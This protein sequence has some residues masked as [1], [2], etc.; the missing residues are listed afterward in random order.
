MIIIG[1]DEAIPTP[2]AQLDKEMCPRAAVI[3][4]RVVA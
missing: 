1:R 3:S 4:I 2:I